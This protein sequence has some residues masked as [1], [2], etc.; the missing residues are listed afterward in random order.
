MRMTSGFGKT[1]LHQIFRS[2]GVDAL[3]CI[4]DGEIG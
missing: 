2:V 4:V 3:L 1:S